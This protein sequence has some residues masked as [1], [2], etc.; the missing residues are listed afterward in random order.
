MELLRK[1]FEFYKAECGK[2][3]NILERD[4]EELRS[5]F[6]LSEK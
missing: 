3:P 4:L 1:R 6:P 5:Y 2:H